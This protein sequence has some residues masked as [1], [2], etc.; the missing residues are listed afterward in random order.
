MRTCTLL[1]S[2]GLLA[3]SPAS[4]GTLTDLDLPMLEE[5]ALIEVTTLPRASALEVTPR[6]TLRWLGG[7]FVQMDQTWNGLPVHGAR[8]SASYDPDGSLRRFVGTPLAKA[9]AQQAPSITAVAARTA[10]E[11]YVAAFKGNGSMWPSRTELG[12]LARDGEAALS[13]VIDV[14]TSEPV[15]AWRIFVDAASGEILGEQQELFTA[16]ANVYASN[17]SASEL[18]EVELLDVDGVLRNDYAWTNSCTDFD[19]QAWQCNAKQTQAL[20]DSVGDFFFTPDPLDTNDPFAEVQMFWHLDLVAR[21]FED[22]FAFRTNFGQFGQSIEGI[23][24]FQLS[25]AF[26]GDADG[27]GV[28]EVA[29][30]Q[31][32]G[33]D[34]SYDAD[35]VYHEFGHAVFGSVVDSGNGRYDEYGRLVA[36]SGLNEGSADFFS[37][38]ITLDPQLGEYAGGGFGSEGAI[39]ELDEDRHCPSDIYG[40]SHTDGQLW[41]SLGW[42]MIEDPAIGPEV[43]AHAFFGALNLWN[44]EVTF[45]SAGEALLEAI[46]DLHESGN[47]DDAQLQRMNELVDVSGFADCSR[48]IALDEG[49][50]PR[51][52]TFGVVY[53][54]NTRWFPMPNQYSIDAPVGTTSL[55]FRVE[56]WATSNPDMEFRVIVRR[57]EHVVFERQGGG[58]FGGSLVVAE[59]DFEETDDRDGFRILLD[60]RS[61]P[62]LEPG[63]TYYFAVT[64]WP[65]EGMSGFGSAEA[66][67]SGAIE[68][69]PALAEGEVPVDGD[70]TGCAGC[71]SRM[72]AGA[73]AGWLAVLGL[74]GLLGLRRR[75]R[76]VRT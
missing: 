57:G 72:D 9:P 20:P 60:D 42:N 53:Q 1:A 44:D 56:D 63:A 30:G 4:A 61:D 21:W 51:Q 35:V 75:V 32:N 73:G 70:G 46:E 47:I 71:A 31:G 58:G 10:A 3:V 29:F 54:G 34:Y 28:P 37:M 17:P 23:V 62:P 15:G 11:E 69:D 68:F 59:S 64:S 25:N 13:W 5:S 16:R 14:S 48:V 40:Q 76:G 74:L 18:E 6:Q 24:N 27:D 36:A 55:T 26:F 43:A 49:V 39:R 2:L 8:L 7:A 22:M 45:G 41:A 12:V 66:E 52:A 38:A 65:T 33:V 19:G 67:V 50:R